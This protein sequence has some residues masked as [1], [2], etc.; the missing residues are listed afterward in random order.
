MYDVLC[1]FIA[2]SK[3][4]FD[5][6]RCAAA[7]AQSIANLVGIPKD[8]WLGQAVL[9]NDLASLSNTLFGPGNLSA[10]G[11]L[12]FSGPIKCSAVNVAASG[13]G[14]M[15][16]GTGRWINSG[17]LDAMGNPSPVFKSLR[18]AEIADVKL[19]SKFLGVFTVAKFGFDFGAYAYAAA[20]CGGLIH[21]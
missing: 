2:P 5:N 8:N 18:V 14:Q 10:A 21:K 4:V 6:D 19:L 12:A 9:G 20:Q 3:S 13:V 15:D 16:S 17:S 11:Q 1:F 7:N